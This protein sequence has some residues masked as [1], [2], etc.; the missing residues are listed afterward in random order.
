[1]SRPLVKICGNVR[2]EQSYG[3][4]ALSPDYMGWILS[5]LSV[6]R[7]YTRQIVSTVRSL[8]HSFPHVQQVAV[9]AGNSVGEVIAAVLQCPFFDVLQILAPSAAIFAVRRHLDALRK[10]LPWR[11]QI[12]PVLRLQGPA[13]V[14]DQS[15]QS[16]WPMSV[17][18]S[19]VPGKAGGTG[20]SFDPRWAQPL[21][22]PFLIAGGLNE[23]NVSQAI[24]LSG[25]AGADV[26][27]GVEA[28]PGQKDL[29]RVAAFIS[30][31]RKNAV[32]Q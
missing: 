15:L 1:M 10:E 29:P 11:P 25:A 24:R 27:S 8:R 20:I 13:G 19:Q 3:V 5:P 7:V 22:R 17:V 12:W 14:L 16:P 31:V 26:S 2:V 6:R 9:F 23:S 4:A 30:A 32:D 21:S 18:D 28:L